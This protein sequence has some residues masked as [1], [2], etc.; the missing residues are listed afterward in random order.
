MIYVSDDPIAAELT[1]LGG[2]YEL[3]PEGTD[4]QVVKGFPRTLAALYRHAQRHGRSAMTISGGVPVT[5][6]AI[7]ARAAPLSRTLARR[8]GVTRGSFVG[9]AMGNGPE[10]MMSFIAITALGGVVVAINSRGAAEELL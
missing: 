6:E 2:P 8:F 1:G 4:R 7:F 9:I 3:V 10:W 5:F